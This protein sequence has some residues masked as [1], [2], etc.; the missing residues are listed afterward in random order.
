M[1]GVVPFYFFSAQQTA[2]V[3]ETMQEASLGLKGSRASQE[4]NKKRGGGCYAEIR[5]GDTA[6]VSVIRHATWAKQIFI[7]YV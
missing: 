4:Y 6:V 2:A 3:Q 1:A 7:L 5:V